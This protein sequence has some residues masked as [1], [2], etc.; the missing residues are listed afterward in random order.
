VAALSTISLVV[1]VVLGLQFKVLIL[2]PAIGIAAA[3]IAASG[4]ANGE[5]LWH[6]ALAIAVAAISVD[7]GYFGGIVV[8]HIF[9]A[10]RVKLNSKA[11][12]R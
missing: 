6:L 8:R 11:L 7:A 4:F 10:A 5:S 2:V 9:G 3:I 1:G 12:E